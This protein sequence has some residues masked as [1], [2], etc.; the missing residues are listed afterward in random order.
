MQQI[1]QSNYKAK[2]QSISLFNFSVF[3]H[4]CS[5]LDIM[6]AKIKKAGM[7][8]QKYDGICSN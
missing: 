6:K 2:T 5:L 7:N 3:R 1:G 8:A 4:L